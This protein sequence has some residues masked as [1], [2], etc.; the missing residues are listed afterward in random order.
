MMLLRNSFFIFFILF[1]FSCGTNSADEKT[2][3][4]KS[5]EKKTETEKDLKAF[6]ATL[7]LS[8]VNSISQAILHYKTKIKPNGTLTCDS[9]FVQIRN[10][11][12]QS[13][14]EINES[15]LIPKIVDENGKVTTED[16][17]KFKKL[18][19]IVRYA[20]QEPYFVT[21]AAYLLK[22]FETCLSPVMNQFMQEFVL[23]D[24]E[25]RDKND[26]LDLSAEILERRVLFWDNFMSKNSSFILSEEASITYGFFLS[27]YLGGSKT[28][29]AFIPVK[30]E[31]VLNEQ[32]KNSYQSLLKKH[33]ATE[34]GKYIGIYYSTLSSSDFKWNAAVESF[35][36]TSTLP[37][38]N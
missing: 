13:A 1:L 17:A 5:P 16:V 6:L 24:E 37:F 26:L 22:E 31:L 32:F 30:N 23:E 38:S 4:K 18:G 3:A 2:T 33:A 8:Q 12:I 15:G 10:F 9:S 28:S 29:S 20:D 36:T 14:I 11:A 19:L 25:M 21:D 7:D 35:L 27:Q 34:T